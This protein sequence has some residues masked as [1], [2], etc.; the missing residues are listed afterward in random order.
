VPRE[1]HAVAFALAPPGAVRLGVSVRML[2]PQPVPAG[3]D[4][5][6]APGVSYTLGTPDG[7]RIAAGPLAEGPAGRYSADVAA[8]VMASVP[9]TGLVRVHIDVRCP[10]GDGGPVDF[11]LYIDPS[12]RVVDDATGEGIAGATVTLLAGAGFVPVPDGST[13]MALSNRVNPGTTGPTGAF[14]WD[15]QPG[16]YELRASAPGWTC[17]GAALPAGLRCVG[18]AVQTGPIAIPPAARRARTGAGAPDRSPLARVRAPRPGSA[19]PPAGS[20]PG[21]SRPAAAAAPR[22]PGSV[23]RCVSTRAARCRRG[24]ERTASRSVCASVPL[25]GPWMSSSRGRRAPPH[26]CARAVG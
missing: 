15:V 8:P 12:G 26:P 25:P 20:P 10:G 2:A 21:R 11:L 4:V 24:H 3:T 1:R 18:D 9:V 7:T 19:G 17:A 23:A 6:P 22:Q 5:L 16:Q 13:V 14:G